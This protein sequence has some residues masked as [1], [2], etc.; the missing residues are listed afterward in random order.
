MSAPGKPSRLLSA[1]RAAT[2]MAEPLAGSLLNRRL[3]RGKE[4][5]D[6]LPERLG[7]PGRVRPRGP[8][9]WIHAASVGES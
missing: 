6:R 5:G 2:G 7:R 3:K 4:D 1:Y 8:I 9:V